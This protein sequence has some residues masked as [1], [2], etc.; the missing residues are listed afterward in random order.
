MSSKS[1]INLRTARKA[2]SRAKKRQQGD[3][4][5]AKFGMTHVEKTKAS[6]ERDKLVTHLDAHKRDR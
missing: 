1:V 4:N 3:E 2:K 6:A 5:A